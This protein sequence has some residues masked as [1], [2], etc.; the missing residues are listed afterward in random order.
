MTSSCPFGI[1]YALAEDMTHVHE[2]MD[3]VLQEGGMMKIE[4]LR[5]HAT[6]AFGSDARFE[7]CSGSADM[8]F[9]EALDFMVER[10]KA[11][12]TES[13][14]MMNITEHCDH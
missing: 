1:F 14:L 4:D 12:K 8:T 2:L 13:T 5:R 9:D 7:S 11:S 6:M 10:G 3:I